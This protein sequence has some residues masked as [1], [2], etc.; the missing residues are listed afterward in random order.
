MKHQ[1]RVSGK[2]FQLDEP[3][4]AWRVEPRPGGWL[5]LERKTASGETERRRIC[6]LDKGG[7][8]SVQSPVMGAYFGDFSR[9]SAATGASA[10]GGAGGF[11]EDF[12]A[13]FPGKV[14][15]VLVKKGAKVAA[16]DKLLLLE[17]MKMEFSIQAPV[18][19]HIKEVR[20]SEGQQ[21]SP[22]DVLLDFEE[23]PS[24]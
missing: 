9:L 20:V 4:T 8:L 10:S 1:F 15:K 2:R 23:I 12:K 13:Q 22:G 24:S 7:K 17:A 14:R 19:G 3:S 21:I 16:G 5:I 11:G 6:V 18:Q